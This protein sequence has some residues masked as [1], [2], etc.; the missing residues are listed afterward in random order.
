[1]TH[2]EPDVTDVEPKGRLRSTGEAALR[3]R[4]GGTDVP[5]A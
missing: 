2:I 5:H 1:M 4:R 3:T